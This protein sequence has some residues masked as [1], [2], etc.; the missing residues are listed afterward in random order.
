M[1][2]TATIVLLCGHFFA[3][4]VSAQS[5]DEIIASIETARD[6]QVAFTE[7]RMSPLLQDPLEVSGMVELTTDGTLTK[8]IDQ[9]FKEA[10]SISTDSVLMERNGRSRKLAMREGGDLWGL[11]IGLRSML[12][13]DS[14]G[15]IDLYEPTVIANEPEWELEL[16]PRTEELAS[17]VTKIV[18]KGSNGKVRFVR[19][20]QSADN[21]QEML[22]LHDD[23]L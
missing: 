12:D 14:A 17:I 8:R 2:R 19:T 16:R 1:I 9:P 20:E 4:S 7:R 21:W 5:A 18:V 6:Q 11:Y 23:Q 13:G 10:I 3:Q 15:V 22:F